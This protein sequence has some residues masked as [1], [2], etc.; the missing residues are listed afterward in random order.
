ML[1]IVDIAARIARGELTAAQVV[2]EALARIERGNGDLNAFITVLGDRAR[3]EAQRLDVELASGRCRGPL[4]GVPISVKDLVDVAGAPT[5]AASRVR[6]AHLAT[7]D[8]PIVARLRDAG[9][10]II[11]KTNLH[12]FAY[13]TTSE[14]S[15]FGPVKNPHDLTRSAGGSSGGS[16]AAI[17]TGMCAG[18]IGT[19][20]G[21]SIR[22]P[23]AACG[24]V[25]LKP[26]CDELP[27]DGV[28]PLSRSLDH[29]GPMA[30]DVRSVRLLYEAMR[31]DPATRNPAEAGSHAQRAADGLRIGIPRPYFLDLLD[32]EVRHAFDAAIARLREAGART[33]EVAIPHA[34]AI[35][36]VYLH[37]QLPE[38]SA[39]H[40]ATL[41]RTPDLYA[42]SV[43]LR[44][45]MGRYVLAEDY[46]RAQQ[47]RQV[48]RAEVD[49]A[50]DNLDVLALPALPIVAPSLGQQTVQLAGRD[51]PVRA[52]MLRL[53]QL[54]N[55][56]GHPAIS[57]PIRA[58][59]G[60]GAGVGAGEGV[61][62][63]PVGFQLVGQRWHTV[64][65]LRAALACE[66]HLA[67]DRTVQSPPG[68]RTRGLQDED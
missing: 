49:R 51:Y 39:Y 56:T 43:R 36:P 53:T 44:L 6:R 13:G 11:G 27:C 52:L 33:S 38:S 7:A 5:T 66:P 55:I 24:I 22:I 28:V 18:S 46:V 12:E 35:G 17:A 2:A 34:D 59:G 64:D 65:L 40:A 45:E 61:A 63:L 50:L 29:V 21:G 54:F 41:E 9:A 15:A 3:E 67:E 8:A 4:H 62:G 47:G 30:A 68:L 57:M 20:T 16:A 60:A 14:E 37:I 1:S 25:G 32:D 58:G 10:I 48:L 26:T 31:R 19:D 42:R 23:A